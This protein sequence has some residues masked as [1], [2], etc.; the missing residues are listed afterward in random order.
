MVNVQY[1]VKI[2]QKLRKKFEP[3]PT[4]VYA[5]GT[6]VAEYQQGQTSM[7]SKY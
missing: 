5:T 6:L 7:S 3:G 2:M 4:N 1:V